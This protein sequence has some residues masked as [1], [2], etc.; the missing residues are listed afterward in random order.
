MIPDD[1]DVQLDT[2]KK[3][4]FET[5]LPAGLCAS[6]QS[7]TKA[8]TAFKPGPSPLLAS[9]TANT[10]AREACFPALRR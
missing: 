2:S 4:P 9:C 7:R 6:P 10:H 8:F 5:K 1:D 3:L